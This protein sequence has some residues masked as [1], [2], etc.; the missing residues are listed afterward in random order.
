VTGPPTCTISAGHNTSEL[1][2]KQSPTKA[3]KHTSESD[4]DSA[5]QRQRHACVG[6]LKRTQKTLKPSRGAMDT[7]A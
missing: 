6:V 5:R 3:L 4:F 7:F 2:R 1:E